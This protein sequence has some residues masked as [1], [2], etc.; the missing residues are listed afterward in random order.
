MAKTRR[1]TR[2]VSGTKDKGKRRSLRGSS[3]Q[4]NFEDSS[5]ASDVTSEHSRKSN[6]SFIVND[7]VIILDSSPE[8]E[9]DDDEIFDRM[10]GLRSSQKEKRPMG[11]SKERKRKRIK[12]ESSS[13]DE[14]QKRSN[15]SESNNESDDNDEEGQF[16]CYNPNCTNQVETRKKLKRFCTRCSWWEHPFHLAIN[17]CL[18]DGDFNCFFCEKLKKCCGRQDKTYQNLEPIPAIRLVRGENPDDYPDPDQTQWK[19]YWNKFIRTSK[20]VHNIKLGD[21]LRIREKKGKFSYLIRVNYLFMDGKKHTWV[22]GYQ[23]LDMSS[24]EIQK[25]IQKGSKEDF[26]VDNRN[27]KKVFPTQKFLTK[28][29]AYY[30]LDQFDVVEVICVIWYKE[31]YELVRGFPE[32][33]IYPFVF[34]YYANDQGIQEIEFVAYPDWRVCKY[35]FF[36]KKEKDVKSIG[37]STDETAFESPSTSRSTTANQTH[38]EVNPRDEIPSTSSAPV[39]VKQEPMDVDT[40]EIASKIQEMC[41]QVIT[42]REVR[43]DAFISVPDFEQSPEN[44]SSDD[45]LINPT[46]SP[47]GPEEEEI[48]WPNE[49]EEEN[50]AREQLAASLLE[51]CMLTRTPLVIHPDIDLQEPAQELKVTWRFPL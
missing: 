1:S 24:R 50:R 39:R 47:V 35:E 30:S 6:D 21:C 19:F 31:Y 45:A 20:S 44:E 11:R 8:S 15:Q 37:V 48:V 41:N 46:V 32:D 16:K 29:S 10:G 27:F 14:V 42:S 43:R 26:E 13:D 36:E 22:M 18:K 33:R 9:D 51:T 4:P 2:L 12:L 49:E 17:D 5:S 25:F 28:E 3:Y 7:N 34:N 38:N 23:I 40:T